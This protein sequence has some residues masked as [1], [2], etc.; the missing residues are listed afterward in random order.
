VNQTLAYEALA[1]LARLFRYGRLFYHGGFVNLPP[2]VTDYP[3]LLCTGRSRTQ[4]EAT[5]EW[6]LRLPMLLGASSTSTA[7][8]HQ[9]STPVRRRILS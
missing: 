1:M 6:L 8:K 3:E 5:A 9:R 7:Q 4:L 2:Q